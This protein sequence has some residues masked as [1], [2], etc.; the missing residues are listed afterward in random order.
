MIWPHGRRQNRVWVDH[1]GRSLITIEE[2]CQYHR[3]GEMPADVG[4]VLMATFRCA[5]H[6][7]TW[8]REG[9]EQALDDIGGMG[10]RGTE[11]FAYVIEDFAGRESD[12]R[13]MLDARGL[14]L[15]ALYSDDNMYEPSQATETVERN[16]EIG[17]FL[18][19]MGAGQLVFGPGRPRPDPVQDVHFKTMVR[20]VDEVAAACLEIDVAVGIHP[21]WETLIQER[22]DISRIFDLVDTSIVKMAPDPS[23]MAKA[24]Y[25]PLEVCETY[26]D[27]I[28]YMHIKDYSPDLDTPEANI[29]VGGY[30]PSLAFFSELGHGII[31]LPAIIDVLRGAGY[32]GWLTI[33][34]DESQTTPRESLEV[35]TAYLKGV[36]GFD[37]TG[38]NH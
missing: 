29:M 24:G 10:Y 2:E 11:T 8:G 6:Q 38:E 12:L 15:T 4:D 16:L 19:K 25:D 27:I 31:D 3:D 20:N 28:S 22:D 13:E 9:L 30:T 26:R 37:I 7:I 34:L 32:D 21:H 35:N 14:T 1:S 17:R 33:E 23:H 18:Q 36:L 5:V